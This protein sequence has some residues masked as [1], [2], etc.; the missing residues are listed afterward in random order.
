MADATAR[1]QLKEIRAQNGN[2]LCCENKDTK[3]INSKYKI[4]I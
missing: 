4:L 3:S 2:N 1:R